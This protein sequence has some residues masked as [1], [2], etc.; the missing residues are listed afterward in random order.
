M[1]IIEGW[2]CND[3]Y[4]LIKVLKNALKIIQIIGPV[5]AIL[6]LTIT[7][8][9]IVKSKDIDSISKNKKGIVNSLIAL[10]ALFLIPAFVSLVM[11][12]IG[13]RTSFT[14]CWSAIDEYEI[15][16]STNYI[17][18][19]IVDEN[20]DGIDDN[21]GKNIQKVYIEPG[22]YER[23]STGINPNA[24]C[25]NN[26]FKVSG[27]DATFTSQTASIISDHKDDL[28]VNNFYDVINNK[29]DGDFKNYVNELGGV[30]SKYYG[31]DVQVTRASQFREIVEYVYGFIALYGFDYDS[32]E[33]Y[34]KW[35]GN[36][37]TWGGSF[38]SATSDA[39]Y[40]GITKYRFESNFP[41]SKFDEAISGKLG[42]NFTTQC[43]NSA[44]MV[45]NKAGIPKMGINSGEIIYKMS[46]IQVGDVL[47]FFD[48]Q[49]DPYDLSSIKGAKGE[50][51]AFIGEVDKKKGTVTGYDGG[52][53]YMTG[54]KY[55]WTSKIDDENPKMYAWGPGTYIV[56]RP[57]Q[58]IQDCN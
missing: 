1:D 15:S 13:E 19:T 38:K 12:L 32:G 17:G 44:A 16:L 40:P 33:K 27:M 48:R 39:F 31:R 24:V 22:D 36:C 56:V 45:Y 18:N 9:K 4:V 5:L 14:S 41:A 51:V 7:L 37:D 57:K 29:Y 20:K 6:S 8:Y 21:T 35:G 25:P 46:D 47:Y 54:R 3:I 2:Y 26:N 53:Y 23:G 34:C 50:H 52:S 43:G 58:L 30:F 49:V 42:L 10:V 55:K 11:G 28:N